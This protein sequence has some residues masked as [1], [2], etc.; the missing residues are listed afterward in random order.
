LGEDK[1]HGQKGVGG[2]KGKGEGGEVIGIIKKAAISASSLF[3]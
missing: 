3:T 1:G 2:R